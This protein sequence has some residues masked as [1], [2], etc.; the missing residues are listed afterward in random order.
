[1]S[2]EYSSFY[3]STHPQTVRRA[4][5]FYDG[6]Q[7]IVSSCLQPLQGAPGVSGCAVSAYDETGHL[8]D[9][10]SMNLGRIGHGCSYFTNENG[11]KVEASSYRV[12]PNLFLYSDLSS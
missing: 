4:C 7:V 1:M 5:G 6:S 12:D 2:T 9:L 8:Y 11:T 3:H 10:P